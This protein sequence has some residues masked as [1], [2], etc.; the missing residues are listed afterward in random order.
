MKKSFV[1]CVSLAAASAVAV[2]A[3]GTEQARAGGFA[4]REQSA[5]F[6]GSSF[7]GNAAGGGGLSGMFWNPAVVGQF[8]GIRTESH[9]AFIIPD[10]EITAKTGTSP[11]LLALGNSSGNIGNEALVG[12]SYLSYQLAPRVVF[13]FSFNAPFGLSSEA[14]NRVWA[15]QTQAR[16][17]DIKTYNG[18]AVLAYRFS[19]SF[20]VGAGLMIE[21]IDGRL[22]QAAFAS[23]AA[24]NAVIKGDDTGFGWTLGAIW[25]PSRTTSIGLGYRS[26]I[27]HDLEGS[28]FVVGA[29]GFTGASVHAPLTLP[30]VATL[31][32][33]Q[34]LTNRVDL[35]GTVEW[36]NWSKVDK[37]DVICTSGNIAGAC[38]GGAG[39]LASSLPL[40]W[41]DGWFVSAGLEYAHSKALTLRTGV[42][43]ERS[44]VQS[45]DERSPRVPDADRIWASLGA[46]YKWNE[47][48]SFDLAYS[49]IFVED[50]EIDRTA[51]GA[52]LVADVSSSIDIVSASMKIKLGAVPVAYEPLK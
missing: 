40:N 50:S 9:Y 15:G 31:S 8:D 22:K 25:N 3:V 11:A 12:S 1:N 44:P 46:T 51:S 6:Q 18:Q 42:A 10:S 32:I 52:R 23:P 47:N 20:I 2:L 19:S 24:P 35:L 36:T 7:A 49:H 37:L 17:S 27:A 48:V 21:R 4:V 5:E 41:H 30:D 43:W 26:Q 45:P 33:R 16:T 38:T 39:T 14:E 28:T 13:G 34:A 29:A